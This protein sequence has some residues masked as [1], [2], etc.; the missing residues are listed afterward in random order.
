MY[1]IIYSMCMPLSKIR[2]I[3]FN[4]CIF[5]IIFIRYKNM[6]NFTSKLRKSCDDRSITK[7]MKTYFDLDN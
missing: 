7:E 1:N 4:Y 3:L 5:F 6:L 2:L